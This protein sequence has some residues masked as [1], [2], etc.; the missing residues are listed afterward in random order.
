MRKYPIL[1]FDFSVCQ[2]C[3]LSHSARLPLQTPAVALYQCETP[4]VPLVRAAEISLV[5]GY[6]PDQPLKGGEGREGRGWDVVECARLLVRSLHVLARLCSITW[7]VAA[8]R[9]FSWWTGKV[10]LVI[11][12]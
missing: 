7:V 1:A 11:M 12:P 4:D 10:C 3:G 5:P 9:S 8:V 6:G 2:L